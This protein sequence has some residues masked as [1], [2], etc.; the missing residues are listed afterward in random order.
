MWIAIMGFLTAALIFFSHTVMQK[1]KLKRAK[2]KEDL[3]LKGIASGIGDRLYAAHPDSK[4]RWVCR[5]I[6]FAVNGGIARIEVIYPS[7]KQQFIDVCLSASNYMALH[8]LNVTPLTD[9]DI[10]VSNNTPEAAELAE[11]PETST[12]LYDKESVV[13]WYNIIL[14]GT[15][16]TLI[17]DLHTQGKVCIEIGQDGKAVVE[18]GGS[19]NVVYDFGEMPDMSLWEYITEKLGSAGLFA[20]IR[21]EH[22]IFISWA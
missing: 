13:S 18:E 6:S 19:I 16:T 3:A 12:K 22:C 9:A 8:F 11:I 7:G 2:N 17:N 10:E 14:I 21:G 5:P 15:L 20:E 4:W 1:S